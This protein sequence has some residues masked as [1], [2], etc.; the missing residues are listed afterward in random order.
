MIG[1]ELVAEAVRDANKNAELNGVSNCSFYAG[2][3]ENIL[4]DVLRNIDREITF[5]SLFRIMN[6]DKKLR[7]GS[8]TPILRI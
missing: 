4:L 3:A 8:G 2:R 6:I 1:V 5:V 7:L